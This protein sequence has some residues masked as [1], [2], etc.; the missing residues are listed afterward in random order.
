M[1]YNWFNTTSQLY[2]MI[3]RK[4]SDVW[5]PKFI[6]GKCGGGRWLAGLAPP[7]TPRF[8]KLILFYTRQKFIEAEID[9]RMILWESIFITR[10]RFERNWSFSPLFTTTQPT[11]HSQN[12]Y[13]FKR[14]IWVEIY[15][16]KI[17]I[18]VK[19]A[20]SKWPYS[21]LPDQYSDGNWLFSSSFSITPEL[22]LLY[23][24]AA[25]WTAFR[26]PFT[27]IAPQL[28]SWANNILKSGD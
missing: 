26:V 6:W 17:T 5:A 18:N 3:W 20:S 25:G 10:R 21:P 13:G 23:T 22:L 11:P 28:L 27:L 2:P 12:C 9:L 19:G 16:S 7:P 8:H 15:T 14:T 1:T 4:C 24:E